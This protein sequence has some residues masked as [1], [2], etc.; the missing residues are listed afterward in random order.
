ML[1]SVALLKCPAGI[2]NRYLLLALRSP[3]FYKEMRAGM[4]GVAITRVTLKKLNVAYFPLP[5]LTEQHRIVAKVD[6]L[7][8]LCEQLKARLRDAQTTQLHLAVAVVSNAV[9]QQVINSEKEVEVNTM[10]ITT[11]LSNSEHYLNQVDG[12]LALLIENEGGEADA[13]AIWNKSSFDLPSF[14][15]QLKKEIK[16]G[17][18]N[19]PSKADFEH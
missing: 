11:T 10:K 8:A 1:S 15:K 14:Y 6:E 9:G 12:V 4:S 2:L 18:I 16:A 5:P 3:F 19:Q 17:Y 7:M 13:K